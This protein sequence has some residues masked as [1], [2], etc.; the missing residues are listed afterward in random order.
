[1]AGH[2][3]KK[4]WYTIQELAYEK[5][6]IKEAYIGGCKAMFF[7][8]KSVVSIYESELKRDPYGLWDK[9]S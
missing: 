7:D 6:L 1:E 2:P 4:A 5:G 8:I 9:K 3:P